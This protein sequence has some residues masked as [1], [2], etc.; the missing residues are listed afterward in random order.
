[1]RR[2][3][4]K[5]IKDIL[6]LRYITDISYGQISRAVGVPKSTVSDY[7]KRFEITTYSIDAFLEMD[8]DTM[9]TIL[10]P[11]KELSY[12]CKNR[13]MPDVEYI[14]Q[15]I[16]KKGVTFEL[17]WQEYKEQ[18][19]NGYGCTQFKEYYYRYKK[20]L[21]PS[22]RQT[23]LPGEKMFI[24]YSGLTLPVVDVKDGTMSKAQIFVAV[25]GASGYTFVHATGSQKQEAFISSH[26]LAYEFFGG[27]P[28]INVPDNL[29]SAVISHSK[30]GIVVNESYAEMARHYQ[31]A[32]EPARPRK[33]QDKGMV[34]QGVQAIQRWILAKLRNHTFFNVDEINQAIAP[35]LDQYNHKVIKRLEQSRT[36][37]FEKY[38]K[39]YLQPL[40]ANRF[41]YKEFKV[42]TVHMDYHIEL[43]RCFY[44]VPFKYLKEKV[45]LRY[46]N[47]TVEVYHKGKL[48][49]THPKLCR[50]NER[51]TRKEH[52]PLN[53]Q[54]QHEKMNP[55]I[56][57]KWASSI[58][59]ETETFV[60]HRLQSA[61]YPVNAYRGIIAILSLEKMYGK[62]TLDMAMGYA[63][64]INTTSV[65]SIRSILEKKLY[66]QAVNNT[67]H[68]KPSQHENLRGSDYY[69]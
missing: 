62:T 4:M 43:K 34:E 2:L 41:I 66:L 64:S 6:K 28:K 14:H 27:V 44:S 16:A 48:I 59:K 5:K 32:I 53:H 45:E 50:A 58:G 15:E 36:E 69:Q 19:P 11:E 33:P 30:K 60:I 7:C 3:S 18:H 55:D 38:D 61:E 63:N 51:S 40:P 65:K 8:E 46:T 67:T 17:L 37:R 26:V 12:H 54:Y 22:M 68:A 21:N 29:K 39:P 57:T 31:C 42:A 13:P 20:R 9:Y 47:T 35:L 56:L 23:Y 49:T 52:M 1:M 25:L 10:F 24:D